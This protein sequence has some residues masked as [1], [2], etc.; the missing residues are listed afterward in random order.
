[1]LEALELVSVRKEW[2]ARIR[3]WDDEE[4]KEHETARRTEVGL[5]ADTT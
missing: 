4:R 3:L 5:C 2:Y 1:M